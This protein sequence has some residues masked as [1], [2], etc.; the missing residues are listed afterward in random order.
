MFIT[1]EGGEGAGKSTQAARLAERLRVA[2]QSTCLTREPGGTPLAN[3][4]RALLLSPDASLHAL[5]DVG[6]IT[7]P[8]DSPSSDEP[9]EP[10]LPLTEALLLSAAR[11]QHAARIRQ[12]LAEGA[13]VISDRYADATLAYQGYGRGYDLATLRMLTQLATEGLLPDLTLLLDLPVAE[14]RARKRQAHADGGEWNRLDEEEIAFHER[15][16]A[17]YLALAAEEPDRW[18]ILDAML[19]VDDLAE[20]IWQIVSTR[21]K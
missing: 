21:M 9:D 2:G 5:T 16:R 12:W 20:R 19:P 6:L 15:V 10:V 14:G 7:P 1:F 11:A 18:V 4:L 13:N 3:G 17:G 8:G